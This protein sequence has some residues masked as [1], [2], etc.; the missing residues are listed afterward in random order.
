MSDRIALA[1]DAS[2]LFVHDGGALDRL[3]FVDRTVRLR[4]PVDISGPGNVLAFQWAAVPGATGAEVTDAMLTL[5]PAVA[6]ETVATAS[7]RAN[8]QGWEIDVPA[9]KRLRAIGLAGF[10]EPGGSA[11]TGDLPTGTRITISFPRP[12]GGFEAPRFTVPAVCKQGSIPPSLTG[13]EFSNGTLTLSPSVE[14]RKVR[15]AL[16][17]GKTPAEFT[18]RASALS[19]VSLVTHAPARDVKV[20][21]PDGATLWAS[22]EF[23]PDGP[24]ADVDLG[25]ALSAAFS[26]QI[27][28]GNAP[29]AAVTVSARAPASAIVMRNNPHG[30]LVRVVPGVSTVTLEGLPARLPLAPPFASERPSRVSADLRIKYA[31][32]RLAMDLSDLDPPSGAPAGTIVGVAGLVRPLPPE[33]LRG[34]AIARL[35]LRGSATEPTELAVDLIDALDRKVLGTGAV[36]QLAVGPIADLWAVLPAPVAI[37]RAVAV[38]VRANTGR[39]LW[40]DGAR[41]T[42]S[43]RIAI[44]DHNPGSRPVHIGGA[45]LAAMVEPVL[46]LKQAAIPA[47]PFAG[48]PPIFASEL[49]VT[50][51]LADLRLEYAR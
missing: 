24:D 12:S 27:A 2:R 17:D 10:K 1:A 21:G 37:D 38:R 42:P 8:G 49:F 35:G 48:A 43:L 34:E 3:G 29:S 41:D 30:V 44:A 9:G 23:D 47:A 26:A 7:F 40:A 11:L 6:E 46:A 15:L 16:V 13:A 20:A 18:E 36:L 50:I 51:E 22:P 19:S 25:L 39:F 28:A 33:A 45:V 31:G 5:G 4:R 32:V 14:A